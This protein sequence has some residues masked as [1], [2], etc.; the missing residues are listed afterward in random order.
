MKIPVVMSATVPNCARLMNNANKFPLVLRY[1]V[2]YVHA[3]IKTV[4][5]VST[6]KDWRVKRD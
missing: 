2:I 5:V 3:I 6:V 1:N 4:F